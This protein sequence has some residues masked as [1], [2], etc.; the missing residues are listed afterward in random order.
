MVSTAIAPLDL[1]NGFLLTAFLNADAIR[2]AR[3]LWEDR[4]VRDAVA[5][6]PLGWT[7]DWHPDDWRWWLAKALGLLLTG[8]AV[9]PGAPFWFDLLSKVARLRASGAP[10]PVTQ[11]VRHREGE[12]TRAGRGATVND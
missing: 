1:G 7:N 5:H 2:I 12:E 6:I 3:A 8:A 10:P 9:S 4:P 11:S